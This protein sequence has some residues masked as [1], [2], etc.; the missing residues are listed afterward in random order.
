MTASE[1]PRLQEFSLLRRQ[2]AAR[3]EYFDQEECEDAQGCPNTSSREVAFSLG[4]HRRSRLYRPN[5]L[6]QI[7]F[8]LG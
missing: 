8:L 4:G 3:F 2:S 1:G 5:K 6:N 7:V